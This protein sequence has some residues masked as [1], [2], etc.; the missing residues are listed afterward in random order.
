M[1]DTTLSMRKTGRECGSVVT[2]K[3][4][5]CGRTLAHHEYAIRQEEALAIGPAVGAFVVERLALLLQRGLECGERET[6]AAVVGGVFA[7][8][9]QA[10]LLDAGP[11]SGTSCVYSSEMHLPRSS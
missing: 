1:F 11:A 7:L 6:D 4:A 5:I 2:I 9:E 10:V 8:R 3:R